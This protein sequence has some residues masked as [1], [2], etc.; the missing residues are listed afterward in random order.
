MMK[1]RLSILAVA[2][3]VFATAAIA[4]E[5]GGQRNQTFTERYG[6]QL[7]LTD[8]QKKQ[9]DELDKKFQEDNATFLESYQKTMAEFREA[10][11][12]NDTAKVDALKPKVDSMR[13]DMTK[14]RTAHEDKIAA[15]FTEDQKTQWKKIKEEREARMKERAQRQ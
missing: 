1:I 2:C 6:Q 13:T 14:L 3:L 12:A 10:R 8:T 7:N 5:R 4:Q 9:I 15:T 11:Q